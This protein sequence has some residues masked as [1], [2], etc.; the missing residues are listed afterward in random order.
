MPH[1]R[2]WRLFPALDE[3]RHQLGRVHLFDV[4]GQ[5][6]RRRHIHHLTQQQLAGLRNRHRFRQQV[7]DVM[8]LRE[9]LQ[10][11]D[12]ATMFAL[13]DF[14]V[15]DVVVEVVLAIARRHGEQLRTRRMNE[16]GTERTDLGGDGNVHPDKV[17]WR[18]VRGSPMLAVAAAAQTGWPSAPILVKF[19]TRHA[20][21]TGSNRPRE[22][23]R[24]INRSAVVAIPART[25]A[26]RRA[27]AADDIERF[28]G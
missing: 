22:A 27:R 15:D 6:L 20:P 14:D 23:H 28:A 3:H 10:N 1:E 2:P 4:R 13:C 24:R 19:F 11:R 5:R 8:H 16:N 7:T 21:R 17:P 18:P 26:G 25:G 12:E 9:P